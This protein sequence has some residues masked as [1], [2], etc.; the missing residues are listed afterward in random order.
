MS[1]DGTSGNL[2]NYVGLFHKQVGSEMQPLGA[3]GKITAT[4]TPVMA[5]VPQTHPLGCI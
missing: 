2:M 1:S 5:S 4:V 3:A